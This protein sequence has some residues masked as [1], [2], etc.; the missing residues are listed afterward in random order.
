MTNQRIRPIAICVFR[1]DGFHGVDDG[2]PFTACWKRLDEFGDGRP[3]LYPDG[4]KDL[5]VLKEPV[6]R[7]V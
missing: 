2:I 4:L 1:K 5:L 6:T 3:P 7:Q